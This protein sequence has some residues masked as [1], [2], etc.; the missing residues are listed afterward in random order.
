MKKFVY[1]FAAG[2]LLLAA[3]SSEPAYKISGTIEGVADGETVYL[4]EA[5]G[6][7]LIKLD[8][9]VVTNGSFV[10]NGR[11]DVAVNRYLTYQAEG[12]RMMTDFFLEN[13]NIVV[14]MG[15]TTTVTGTPNNDIYQAYKQEA[16]AL[17]KE[18]R[19]LYEKSKE[20]GL[21]EEQNAEI[22]KQFEELDGKLNTLTFNTIDANITNGRYPLVAGQLLQH[23]I[24]AIA[25]FGS[26]GA[27][28]IPEQRT[29][30]QPVEADRSIG[31]D[32]RRPEIH[33]FRN[34]DT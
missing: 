3:C 32:S 18:M 2:T 25:G 15:E 1:L 29:H 28:R 27:G 16:G 21:T 31:Q 4:Q 14:A 11:Q 12:K 34:A 10:F 22:E 26:Q 24:A 30:R 9:A 19:A 33:R 13:G 23:G 17:N 7:E 8:S 20:E 6:R 5:K